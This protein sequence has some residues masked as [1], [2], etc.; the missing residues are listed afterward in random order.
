MLITRCKIRLLITRG[1]CNA[2]HKRPENFLPARAE[3]QMEEGE[4]ETVTPSW[5]EILF[6]LNLKRVLIFNI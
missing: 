5:K 3:L 2:D 6:H 4:L 1:E